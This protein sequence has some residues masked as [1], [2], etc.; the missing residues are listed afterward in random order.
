MSVGRNAARNPSRTMTFG[1]SSGL[2]KQ[3]LSIEVDEGEEID[4]SSSKNNSFV[5]KD[6]SFEKA[7]QKESK[8]GIG[9]TRQTQNSGM[10]NKSRTTVNPL[11]KSGTQST[12]GSLNRSTRVP[13]KV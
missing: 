1:T 3:G 7:P 8:Y 13:K 6:K 12:V 9:N 5:S 2:K 11:N 4:G 10:V